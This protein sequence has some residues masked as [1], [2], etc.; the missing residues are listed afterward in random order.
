MSDLQSSQPPQSPDGGGEGQGVGGG[1][2]G[3]DEAGGVE[4]DAVQGE[5]FL[6][7]TFT[8]NLDLVLLWFTETAGGTN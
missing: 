4:R 2:G 7:V 8:E 1:A 6:E 3:D 5:M